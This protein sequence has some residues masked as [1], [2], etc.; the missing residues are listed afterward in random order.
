MSDSRLNLFDNN[1][2]NIENE[3]FFGRSCFI[4]ASR[5]G[6]N[7]NVI[8]RIS[9]ITCKQSH[10]ELLVFKVLYCT[11][12]FLAEESIFIQN[13]KINRKHISNILLNMLNARNDTGWPHEIIAWCEERFIHSLNGTA[14]IYIMNVW[15]YLYSSFFLSL[16]IP[17]LHMRTAFR[18]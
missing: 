11:R 3:V 17:P 4:S 1:I 18:A 9:Q 2:W 7:T 5:H 10:L 16:Y 15:V 14:R 12:T 6:S 8:T 13:V